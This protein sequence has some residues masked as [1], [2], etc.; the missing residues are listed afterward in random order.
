M[1]KKRFDYI[2]AVNEGYSNEEIQQYLND[3][4][5][6]F[7]LVGAVNEG[8]EPQEIDDYLNTEPQVKKKETQKT[9]GTAF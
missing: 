9:K 4:G 7:D 1:G 8:Y 2:G 6:K 3:K 5:I